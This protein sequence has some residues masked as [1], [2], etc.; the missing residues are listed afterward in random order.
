MKNFLSDHFFLIIPHYYKQFKN[1]T[2]ELMQFFNQSVTY[3]YGRISKRVQSLNYFSIN[4][5]DAEN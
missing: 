5:K 3:S 4:M 1:G 2:K